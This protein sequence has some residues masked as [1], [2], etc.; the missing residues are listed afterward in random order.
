MATELKQ[1]THQSPILPDAQQ[2]ILVTGATGYIGGQLVPKL[3]E[4]GYQVRVMVRSLDQM[5]QRRWP[6]AEIVL[7]NVLVYDDLCAAL[8]GIDCAFY[9]IHSL[10]LGR[11]KF[12]ETDDHG[13][14]NFRKAAEE[15]NLTRIIYLGS[16]GDPKTSLSAHLKSRFMVAD[17]LRKGK[18]PV[19]FLKA[20]V[21]MGAGSASYRMIKYLMQNCPFF[22]FPRWANSNCQ[23]IA[24]RDVLRYLIG[25]LEN[26]E[27]IGQTYDIGGG[28]VLTYQMMLKSQGLLIGKNPLFIPSFFSSLNVYACIATMFIPLKFKLIISLM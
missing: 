10:C 20:A 15:N 9:F 5:D 6:G 26:D 22:L 23:P 28:T 11:K 3:L 4:K 8:D 1:I 17:Q 14:I 13:A 21:I 7:A 24:I 25:C 19:T 16:L 18:T 27:T 12:T 2:K